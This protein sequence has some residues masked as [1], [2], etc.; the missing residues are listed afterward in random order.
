MIKATQETMKAAAEVKL[1]AEAAKSL[2]MKIEKE[3]QAELIART[4]AKQA[5][6]ELFLKMEEQLIQLVV[7][8]DH[9]RN[10]Q[11]PISDTSED[12]E[13]DVTPPEVIPLKTAKNESASE[14]ASDSRIT[15]LE[16]TVEKIQETQVDM[17]KKIEESQA[18]LEKRMDNQDKSNATMLS[19]LQTLLS[20]TQ[21]PSQ[22]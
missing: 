14:S 18:E 1:Q 3:L 17:Q 8:R 13:E 9:W 7:A 12:E 5:R 22:S 10:L 19:M 20:R 21:P 2:F 4:E 16:K 11:E 15:S 6:R